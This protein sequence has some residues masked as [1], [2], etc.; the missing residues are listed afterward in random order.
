MKISLILISTLLT[1]SVFFP[2]FLF[3]YNGFKNTSNIKHRIESLIKNN[4]ILYTTKETW[5]HNFIGISNDNTKLT[6]VHFNTDEPKIS[7]IDLTEI[8]ECHILK[9]Q[10]KEK[11]KVI[12]LKNLDL[13][14]I[15]K[16]SNKPNEIVNFFNLDEDLSEDYELQRIEKWQ[17]IIKT[18]LPEQVIIKKAS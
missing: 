14:F 5:H 3:I 10:V 17:Q 2:L 11:E 12:R 6:Y 16:A 13:E 4:G 8:K 18:S 7:T 15:Y 1:F 9:S